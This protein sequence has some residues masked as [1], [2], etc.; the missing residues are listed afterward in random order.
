[1]IKDTTRGLCSLTYTTCLKKASREEIF[2]YEPIDKSTPKHQQTTAVS[3]NKQCPFLCQWPHQSEFPLHTMNHT[4]KVSS[5]PHWL[6]D[7]FSVLISIF[8]NCSAGVSCFP[9]HTA[10][11]V[12]EIIEPLNWKRPLRTSSSTISPSPPCLLAMSLSVTSI[13]F[14]KIY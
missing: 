5:S 4:E 14:L 10:L 13:L 1:M 12:L 9:F 8:L 7:M 2:L 11:S 3:L 6:Y